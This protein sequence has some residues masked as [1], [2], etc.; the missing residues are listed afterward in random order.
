ADDVVVALVVRDGAETLPL[1][2]DVDPGEGLVLLARDPAAEFPGRSSQ[3]PRRQQRHAQGQERETWS[4][5]GFARHV[6]FSFRVTR[7]TGSERRP[8]R[9]DRGAVRCRP[10]T[11]G[12]NQPARMA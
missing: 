6:H 5:D 8:G 11:Q 1:D 10:W 4:P 9:D 3:C 12:G 2:P 7:P